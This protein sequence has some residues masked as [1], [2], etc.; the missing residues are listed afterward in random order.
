MIPCKDYSQQLSHFLRQI[1][2]EANFSL[3]QGLEFSACTVPNAT[4]GQNFAQYLVSSTFQ[5][6]QANIRVFTR[7]KFDKMLML[8]FLV[9]LTTINDRS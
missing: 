2:R 1:E 7:L 9:I 8:A 3:P 4:P 6:G 5:N